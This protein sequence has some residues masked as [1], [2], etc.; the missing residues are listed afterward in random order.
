MSK[1]G[2]RNALKSHSEGHRVLCRNRRAFHDYALEETHEAG[3]ALVGSEVKS[4]RA[5]RA[6]LTDAHVVIRA[7][8][9]WLV[10]AT[11]NEYPWAHQQNHEPE[12]DRKLLLHKH[13]I[14]KL[15]VKTEQRGYSLIPL[16]LYLREGKVKVE[17]GLGVGK[18]L[19]EKR[20]SKR[21]AE[22]AREIEQATRRR[23]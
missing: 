7:G 21:E 2:K 18:R 15:G 1:R 11:I 10:G 12:R 4:L 3:I 13:E 22:A 17:L 20:E 8:E 19:Y 5:A 14:R 16:A 6:A 9:A 23:R